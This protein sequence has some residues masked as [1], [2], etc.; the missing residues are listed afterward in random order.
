MVPEIT[1]ST[2]YHEY[3]EFVSNRELVFS[4]CLVFF[5]FAF[6]AAAVDWFELEPVEWDCHKGH[7]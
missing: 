3:S 7:L 6:S 5:Q 2:Q 1:I 4:I